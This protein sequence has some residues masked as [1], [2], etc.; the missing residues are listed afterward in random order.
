MQILLFLAWKVQG[1]LPPW[2]LLPQKFRPLGSLGLY[3]TTATLLSGGKNQGAGN[4]AF[5]KK[6]AVYKGKGKCGSKKVTAFQITQRIISDFEEKTYAGQWN[7][8]AMQDRKDWFI[9]QMEEILGVDF[10]KVRR[11][12]TRHQPKTPKKNK[13]PKKANVSKDQLVLDL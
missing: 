1:L 5:D 2:H 6:I 9:S 4:S 10:S 3:T 12:S 7:V 13:A 8:V 11:A